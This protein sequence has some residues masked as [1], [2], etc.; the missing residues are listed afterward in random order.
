MSRLQDKYIKDVAPAL[1]KEFGYTNTHQTP[2]LVKVVVN[3]GVGR[4]TADSKHLAEVI[5]TLRKV[6]GQKPVE[7]VAKKSIAG[8]KLR[9]TNKIGASVTLRGERMYDFLDRLVAIALPRIR[10]FRGISDTAFD[11]QGNYSLGITEQSIFPEIPYEEALNSHGL[12][13]NIVTTAHTKEE[14]K[15]LLELMGFPFRRNA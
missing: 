4:A 1:V 10:D 6:T 14:G 5:E 8:F 15:K 12:Q 2:R 13:V 3:A 7:T 11:P 9:E